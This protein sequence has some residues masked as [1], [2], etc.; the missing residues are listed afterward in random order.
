MSKQI[1][2]LNLQNAVFNKSKINY[3]AIHSSPGYHS[4]PIFVPDISLKNVHFIA[5]GHIKIMENIK[6]I[7]SLPGM[8]QHFFAV[9]QRI[10]IA[11]RG[12]C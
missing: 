12:Q 7:I 11:R 10:L 4:L 6:K 3:I 2:K 9:L 8:F 5:P 1:P